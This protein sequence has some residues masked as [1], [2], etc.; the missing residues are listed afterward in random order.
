MRTRFEYA[1]WA[2]VSSTSIWICGTPGSPGSFRIVGH[3]YGIQ[4]GL[5]RAKMS[6]V[7]PRVIGIDLGARR[8]G[9][10]LTDALG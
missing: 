4:R 3:A 6:T 8:I 1:P 2:I 7:P 9:V 10:A 5:H